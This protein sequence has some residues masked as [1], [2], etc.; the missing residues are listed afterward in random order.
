MCRADDTFDTLKRK[1]ELATILGTIQ[2]SFTNFRYL[3]PIWRKNTEEEA[4][5]GVSF[6]GLMDSKLKDIYYESADEL[7]ALKQH[8]VEVNKVWAARI[9]INQSAAITCVN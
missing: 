5:L 1:V 6:T 9:G 4:L 2:A 3:R 8:S 7:E